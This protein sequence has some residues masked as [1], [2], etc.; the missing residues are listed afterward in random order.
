MH[1]TPNPLD[2][3]PLIVVFLDVADRLALRQTNRE[4]REVVDRAITTLTL[5]AWKPLDQFVEFVH[6]ILSRGS[7]PSHLVLQH[8]DHPEA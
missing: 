5:D 6:G 4:F 7:H 1:S 3:G 2:V 8:Q